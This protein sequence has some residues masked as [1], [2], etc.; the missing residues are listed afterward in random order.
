MWRQRRQNG[1]SDQAE[2]INDEHKNDEGDDAGI[3][4]HVASERCRKRLKRHTTFPFFMLA[5]AHSGLDC[6]SA[7]PRVAMPVAP[8]TDWR[9]G[10]F[11]RSTLVMCMAAHHFSPIYDRHSD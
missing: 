4:A 8:V 3:D 1:F 11:I 10:V 6:L 5:A 7:I 2:D 9:V